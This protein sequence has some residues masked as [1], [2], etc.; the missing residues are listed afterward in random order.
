MEELAR[1]GSGELQDPQ[2][3]GGFACLGRPGFL[4]A[5]PM[6][7]PGR[8]DSGGRQGHQDSWDFGSRCCRWVGMGEAAGSDPV[9]GEL[10]CSSAALDCRREVLKA[11][12]SGC[13]SDSGLGT[14]FDELRGSEGPVP[15][16]VSAGRRRKRRYLALAGLDTTASVN[17][18]V[19][20]FLGLRLRSTG[21]GTAR[22]SRCGVGTLG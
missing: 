2:R 17:S 16:Q 21:V 14:G 11:A 9:P 7:A 12:G 13:R 18:S 22:R 15:E 6:E 1:P 4:S 10:G 5:V 20:R 3:R 8:L 19:R